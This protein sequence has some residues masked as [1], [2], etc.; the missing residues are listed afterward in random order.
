[1]LTGNF[2]KNISLFLKFCVFIMSDYGALVEYWDRDPKVGGSNLPCKTYLHLYNHT[3]LEENT[4]RS[5][6]MCM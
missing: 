5:M 4:H 6:G 2:E 3:I 1:M